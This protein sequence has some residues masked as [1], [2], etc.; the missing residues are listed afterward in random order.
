[1]PYLQLSAAGGRGAG[2]ASRDAVLLAAWLD[3]WL[4]LLSTPTYPALIH[5]AGPC[6]SA[7]EE[8]DW[9]ADARTTGHAIPVPAGLPGHAVL[10]R[11]HA[12]VEAHADYWLTHPDGTWRQAPAIMIP[13]DPPAETTTVHHL[14]PDGWNDC[15]TDGGYSVG[16]WA[17]V[18]C[19]SC[20]QAKT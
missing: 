14:R 9:T 19:T 3:E 10:E 16:Y 2:C 18:T 4:P 6:W 1:M 5:Y 7:A 12:S 17:S 20:R 13:A 15:G 8:P 11:L